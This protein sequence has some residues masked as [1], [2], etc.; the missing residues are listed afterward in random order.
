LVP[1]QR[2]AFIEFESRLAAESVIKKYQS[3]VII[4]GVF[5]KIAWAKPS[6]RGIPG[7][8]N[9]ALINRSADYYPSMD[10]ERMGSKIESKKPLVVNTNANS[11]PLSAPNWK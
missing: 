4:N 10:S 1:A 9:P 8:E 5:L 11:T 2:C 3:S 6:Q 7:S